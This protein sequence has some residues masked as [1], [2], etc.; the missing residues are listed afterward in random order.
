MSGVA[1]CHKL[2]CGEG[3]L[4]K[5]LQTAH[6]VIKRLRHLLQSAHLNFKS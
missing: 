6:S 5:A 1:V 2:M 4:V 3:V